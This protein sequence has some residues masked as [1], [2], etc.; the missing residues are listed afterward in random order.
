M[1]TL[2]EFMFAEVY[3]AA[4][5]RGEHSKVETVVRFLFDHYCAHPDALPPPWRAEETLATRVTDYISGMTDRFCIRAYQ[6]LAVPR[7]FAL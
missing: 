5:A 7:S 6:E 4:P 3:L 1:N 2:R